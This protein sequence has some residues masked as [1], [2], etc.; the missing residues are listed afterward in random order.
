VL[1]AD[2]GLGLA[3]VEVGRE[4]ANEVCV[5]GHAHHPIPTPGARRGADGVGSGVNTDVLMQLA[6]GALLLALKIVGP[7]LLAALVTGTLISI[8]QAATQIQ[9]QTVVLVP[10]LIAFVA[11][12]IILGPWMMGETISYTHNLWSQIPE[13]VR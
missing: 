11:V 2:D 9:E 12:G 3:R 5:V 4:P 13:L 10:K 8:I 1:E 6:V 7:F